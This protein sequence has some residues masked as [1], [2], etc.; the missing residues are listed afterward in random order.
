MSATPVPPSSR[1]TILVAVAWPYASGSRHV[2]HLAGAYLPADIFARYHRLRGNRVLM[3][4]GSD[5]H[6]TPITVRADAERVE[7]RALVEHFHGEFVAECERLGISWDLFTTTMTDNHRTTAQHLFRTLRDNGYIDRRTTDQFYDP[8]DER[9]LPDRYIEGTC[10]HCG[11]GHARGDQCDACSRPLDAT[12]LIEPRSAVSG[13]SLELRS[14]EHHFLQLSAFEDELRTWIESQSQWRPFV[15]TWS[16]GMLK[17]GLQDRAVT[18]DLTWGV[19]IPDEP[20]ES[21]KRIY[22][23]FEAVTGYLSASIEWA[24]RQGQPDLWRQWWAD[25]TAE[26]VYFIGK[27][28]IPFH[29]IIWPAMLLGCGNLNLPTMIPANHYVTFEG[30]KA[31]ASRG[32]GLS[33]SEALERYEPD[34]LR[35]GLATL[36]PESAD[37]ALSVELLDT[38]IQTELIGAWGNLTHRLLTMAWKWHGKTPTS[39]SRTAA[40]AEL[41]DTCA[42]SLAEAGASI[43]RVELR[44]ALKTLLS[45][46][47]ATN[48][49]LSEHEPWR[50]QPVDSRRADTVLSTALDAV[51]T[52]AVGL[53]PFLPASSASL[54]ASLGIQLTPSDIDQWVSQPTV[55]GHPLPEPEPPYSLHEPEAASK[56]PV[57]S[58]TTVVESTISSELLP[59]ADLTLDA[60]GLFTNPSLADTDWTRLDQIVSRESGG[61]EAVHEG[62]RQLRTELGVGWRKRVPAPISLFKRFGAGDRA[63]VRT[64]VDFYN[65][66]SAITGLALGLHDLD[67][68]DG[69]VVEL[70]IAADDAPF[71]RIGS[72]PDVVQAGEYVYRDDGGP[73]CRL[74]VVQCN[75]TAANPTTERFLLIFQGNPVTPATYV[76]AVRDWTRTTLES[77]SPV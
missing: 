65:R 28:N 24:Q 77:L 38:K 44:A 54:L 74:E 18:R 40:D 36:L 68:L 66:V 55:G 58:E 67:R 76:N 63:P 5:A 27:D 45:A 23:W 21:T 69:D 13:V 17:G 39:G 8:V 14:T 25:P 56:A 70:A 72:R 4:S 62:Y 33:I 1:R 48:A 51:A 64:I 43:E 46:V 75:R 35:F 10:P 7:P 60:P 42:R 30:A 32:A 52:I 49:F 37:T 9:F 53:S 19:P 73:V 15:R 31:S 61:L 26:S 3:V 20:A 12:D 47:R 6:G 71:N 29:S 41:L 16:L 57:D 2:G 59:V 34:A 11:D 50:L 22:V